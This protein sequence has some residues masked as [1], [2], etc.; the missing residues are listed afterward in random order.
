MKI[1][2]LKKELSEKELAKEKLTILLHQT[3]GQIIMLKDLIKKEENP[4]LVKVDVDV[5]KK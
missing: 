3:I 4:I 2:D 1:E 5:N